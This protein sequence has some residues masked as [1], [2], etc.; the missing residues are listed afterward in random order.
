MRIEKHQRCQPRPNALPQ[1]FIELV[2][3]AHLSREL[4][5]VRLVVIQT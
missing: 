3:H 5:C 4:R 1:I 2:E